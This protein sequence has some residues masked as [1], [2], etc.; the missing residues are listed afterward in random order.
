M[1]TPDKDGLRYKLDG[2]KGLHNGYGYD[3]FDQM[4]GE[5]IERPKVDKA[6]LARIF[7]VT[8][9]TIYDWLP[10]LK[11]QRETDQKAEAKG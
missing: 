6:N 1:N 5:D 9:P 8:R 10:Q 2:T 7:D 4:V 11:T 3:D